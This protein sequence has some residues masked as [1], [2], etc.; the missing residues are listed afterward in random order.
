MILNVFSRH[1]GLLRKMYEYLYWFWLSCLRARLFGHGFR[2]IISLLVAF[3]ISL[4][5][6]LYIV[7]FIILV[8]MS[9]GRTL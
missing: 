6:A 8:F 5:I 3:I 9:T 4:F 7:L 2:F 1:Y